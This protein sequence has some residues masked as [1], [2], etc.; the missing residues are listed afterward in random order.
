[1]RVFITGIAGFLGSHLAERLLTMGHEVVGCDSL[2]GGELVNVPPEAEFYQYDCRDFNA[3]LKVMRGCR[4]IYHCAATA[5]EG[6][7]VFSPSMVMDNIVTGSVSVI[8]AAIA[9]G[10]QRIVLCSSM[11]R[12]GTNEVA[13]LES[14]APR[15]Q[16]PYGIAKV[17]AEQA[18]VNLAGV[19]G[20]EYAIAVPHNIIGARQK[21]DDPYRNVA[22]IMANLMLQGRAPFI[23]GDGEQTRCFSHVEDCLSCLLT[24]GFTGRG[25]SEVVNIGPDEDFVSVNDLFRKLKGII[26]F[27][28]QAI[29]LTD[30]PQEVKNAVCSADK[31]RDLLGYHTTR[32]LDAGLNDIVDYIRTVGP[33][34]FRYHLDIEIRNDR[35]PRTWTERLM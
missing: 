1:M 33:R 15:P 29:H 32:T 4:L 7:S 26:G 11:A 5:Y 14:Y 34:K 20:I 28:C 12:Y 3:M 31:A 17:A 22:S 18:L 10:V 13:F 16:D 25:V 2:I 8:S 27:D 6:L 19:H 23:Y 30:R 21:F 24:M 35:T 9:N